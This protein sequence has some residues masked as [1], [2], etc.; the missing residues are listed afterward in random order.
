MSKYISTCEV[1][2]S[3]KLAE[4]VMSLWLRAENIVKDAVPGQFVN[5][6]S[7]SKEKLLPRPISI[8]DVDKEEG[9]LRLVYRIVGEGTKEFSL[10]KT[11]D[12]LR[13]LGPLGNG[14][15]LKE[16]KNL[17][18][19]GG[20]GIPP[21]VYLAKT[22]SKAGISKDNLHVVLG[23]RDEAFLLDEFNGIATV[24]ISSD[25]GTIGMKGNVVELARKEKLTGDII[26]ACGPKPMLH[27]LKEY[28]KEEGILAEFSLEERMAC[29]VGACLA[30]VCES[31]EIDGHSNVKNKRV[32]ADGPVF[33]AGEIVI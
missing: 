1:I 31:N 19:G 30:C 26:Y 12:S 13:V 9:S 20:I 8:C 22:L 17:L 24:H 33:Y 5:V 21:M 14:Y 10:L 27:F 32:C 2:K 25:F 28:A 4:G 15:T 7:N 6:Y 23:Y 29:G 16:G 11:G 3:E 18:F